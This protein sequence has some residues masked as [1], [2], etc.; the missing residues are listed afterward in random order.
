MTK[1]LDFKVYT[2]FGTLGAKTARLIIPKLQ[3][4]CFKHHSLHFSD[5]VFSAYP[6]PHS[7]Q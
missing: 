2:H 4:L 5:Q 3:L 7:L 1:N 6:K